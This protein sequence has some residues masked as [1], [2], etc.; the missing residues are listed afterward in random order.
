MECTNETKERVL[1]SYRSTLARE[2]S[3]TAFKVH[4]WVELTGSSGSRKVLAFI[5]TG[6]QISLIPEELAKEIG[7]CPTDDRAET[8]FVD[9]RVKRNCKPNNFYGKIRILSKEIYFICTVCDKA[10]QCDAAGEDGKTITQN[11]P[12]IGMSI[13]RELGIKIDTAKSMGAL[14]I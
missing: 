1:E 5:D 11:H 2:G 7:L 6:A 9:D 3:T 14:S 13:L 10:D 12:I 8:W 4:E